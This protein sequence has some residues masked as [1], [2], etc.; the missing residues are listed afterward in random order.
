MNLKSFTRAGAF[1]AVTTIAVA[2]SFATPIPLGGGG[3]VNV[4]NVTGDLVAVSSIPACIAFS[5]VVSTCNGTT[6][7]SV[8][9][10]DPI[11]GT[12]GTIKDIG[13]SFPITAFKTVNLTIAGGPAIFDLLNIITPSGF[14]ACTTATT[15][16]SC[17]T[18]TF[19][20]TQSSPT[21]VAITLSTNEIGYLGSSATGSTQYLGIFTT[22]IS[23][24]LNAFGCVDN[25]TGNCTA[26]IGN[27]LAF[28][29]TGHT[30]RSTWSA[31][32]SPVAG[33]VPEPGTL[34]MLLTG[35]GLM[36]VSVF[37]KKARKAD[38]R[39]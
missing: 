21:Q 5:G 6:P 14:S 4:S 2:P 38:S 16:G 31:T 22:Q 32:E 15:S 27:I 8:S 30:I 20:L 13:T 35:A 37:V 10:T 9:G 18:G 33:G 34:V 19:V 12:T 24:T 36:G 3:V 23:G 1:L 29:A 25:G 11:F 17:S 7:I 28:E 39:S 26:T